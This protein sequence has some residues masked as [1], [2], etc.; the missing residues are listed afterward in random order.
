MS[1]SIMDFKEGIGGYKLKDEFGA[2]KFAGMEGLL[3]G[4]EGAEFWGWGMV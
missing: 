3:L 2:G 4:A 1:Y